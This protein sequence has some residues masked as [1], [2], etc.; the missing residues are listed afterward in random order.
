MSGYREWE[1]IGAPPTAVGACPAPAEQL[2]TVRAP[3]G[4][5]VQ[6]TVSTGEE[7][8]DSTISVAWNQSGSATTTKEV[9]MARLEEEVAAKAAK[10]M[11]DEAEEVAPAARPIP[12]PPNP[13]T[14]AL[15]RLLADVGGPSLALVEQPKHYVI[16]FNR[17]Q[18]WLEGLW[19]GPKQKTWRKV[20]AL[21]D[22]GRMWGSGAKLKKVENVKEAVELWALKRPGEDLQQWI[23]H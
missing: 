17:N 23:V 15:R 20:E 5:K 3:R 18:V 12:N 14:A 11:T 10:V 13:L 21:L 19:S 16:W 22:G 4:A 1:V 6:V 7:E 9:Q 2:I 8:L